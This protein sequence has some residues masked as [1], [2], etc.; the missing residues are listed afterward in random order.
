MTLPEATEVK[1]PGRPL[2]IQLLSSLPKDFASAKFRKAF[3]T[4]KVKEEVSEE[5]KDVEEK[6]LKMEVVLYTTCIYLKKRAL[7]LKKL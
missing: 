6:P 5:K 7:K 1:K 4:G 2:K 3:A